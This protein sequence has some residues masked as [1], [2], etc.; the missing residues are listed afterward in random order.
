MFWGFFATLF[1]M[2][3][4][5]YLRSFAS[6][7]GASEGTII[8][9]ET[10]TTKGQREAS[11]DLLVS[12]IS[13]RITEMRPD[14]SPLDTVIRNIGISVPIR[15]WKTEHYAVDQRGRIDVV[16]AEIDT[17]LVGAELLDVKQMTC[18]NYHIWSNDDTVLFQGIEG[19]D[20]GDLVANVVGRVPAD[21]KLNLVFLNPKD[22][23]VILIPQGTKAT[24]IGNAKGE[25]DASTDPYA[26]MPQKA[27]N[28]AQIHMAQVEETIYAKL[29]EKEVKW[30]IQDY[31]LQ[32]LYDLRSSM[33]FT[34][35]FGYRR[36]IYDV[37]NNK[38]KY[39][40]GGLV[41]FIEKQIGYVEGDVDNEWFV[42]A[43]KRIF[44]GNSGSDT[45]I[46]FGGD[47]LA[48]ELM[49][50]DT[51]QKQ[52]EAKSTEVVYGIKFNKIETNFGVILFKRH[53]LFSFAGWGKNGVLLDLNNIEKHVFKPM[54][55]RE[56][57]LRQT[58]LK[59]ANAHVVDE[60]FCLMLR[61]PDTHAIISPQ[62][63]LGGEA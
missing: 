56:L 60:A 34:S 27:H 48:A 39:F 30:D 12:T 9:G 26:I 22:S 61:Y 19:A 2:N 28:F 50:V 62:D 31:K 32:A 42:D 5:L 10:V 54:E 43:T 14:A 45:R 40:S 6:P 17:T 11:S 21:G 44:T 3:T 49:K 37:T 52:I 53:P 57:Q 63:S 59:N 8:E 1:A 51:V 35:L 4:S 41:R 15:S 16:A 55:A 38:E 33:E 29:H 58:G 13:K 47:N 36:Q 46:M 20:G 23:G 7:T 18:T 24:R 25:N